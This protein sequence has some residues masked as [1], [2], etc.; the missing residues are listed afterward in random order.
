VNQ[1]ALDR[2]VASFEGFRSTLPPSINENCVR[3]YH[4]IVDALSTASGEALDS[5]K[6][7]NAE[8]EYKEIDRTDFLY[9]GE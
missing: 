2:A 9:Q 1:K 3:E 4:A 6:I 7:G 8:L 5:F